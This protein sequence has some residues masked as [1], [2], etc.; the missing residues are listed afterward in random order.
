MELVIRFAVR[1]KCLA[2]G[3]DPVKVE[4]ADIGINTGGDYDRFKNVITI[5]TSIVF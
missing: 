5:N 3:Y 4:F 2:R 1:E